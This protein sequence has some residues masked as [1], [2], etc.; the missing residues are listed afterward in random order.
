MPEQITEVQ[1]LLLIADRIW[2]LTLVVFVLWC[3]QGMR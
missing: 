2:W 1:A 3:F